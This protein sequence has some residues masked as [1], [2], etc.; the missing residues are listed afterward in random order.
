MDI[1]IFEKEEFGKIG[2]VQIEGKEYFEAN[3]VAESLGYKRPNDT[4]RERC[5]GTIEHSTLKNKGGT[6]TVNKNI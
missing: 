2:V 6:I 1:K 5:K 4:I 3:A